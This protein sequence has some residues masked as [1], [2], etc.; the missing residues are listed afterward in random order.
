MFASIFSPET[1]ENFGRNCLLVAGGFMV[2][3]L[4]GWVI[5]FGVNRYLLKGKGP[6]ELQKLLR[7]VCGLI[8]AIIVALTVFTGGGKGPGEG[9][10]AG[11][12]SGEQNTKGEQPK[13]DTPTDPK[14][15]PK[16]PPKEPTK[17]VSDGYKELTV[18][19]RFLGSTAI[20]G[21]KAYQIGDDP[22]KL[23]IEE[24]QGELR[25]KK[26]EAGDKGLFIRREWPGPSPIN[27]QSQN[28]TLLRPWL[29][30][31]NIR[32]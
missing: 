30:K 12:G 10:P 1:W 21:K 27:E 9:G 23:T 6:E 7:L 17:G 8:V 26:A 11:A 29:V 24:L 4:G 14:V 16:D 18:T 15:P 13:G 5:G 25:K 28:W 20:E 32:Y 2:G 22:R 19:V 3:Y 31:E